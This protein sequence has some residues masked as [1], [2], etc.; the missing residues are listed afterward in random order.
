M[1]DQLES[2]YDCARADDDLPRL[3]QELEQWNAKSSLTDEEKETRNR[4]ENQIHFIRNKC[5][6]T[7][8][9]ERG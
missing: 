5:G 6:I 1:L 4:V 2:N 3:L 9:S 7:K 8:E